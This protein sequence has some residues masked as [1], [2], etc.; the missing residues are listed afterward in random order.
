MGRAAQQV[1]AQIR[2]DNVFGRDETVQ[3]RITEVYNA[4]VAQGLASVTISNDDSLVSM[5]TEAQAITEGNPSGEIDASVPFILSFTRVGDLSRSASV[6]YRVSEWGD[7]S[8]SSADFF[9]GSFPS[10]QVQFAAGSATASVV[11]NL[12][13]EALFES[14]E[15]FVVRLLTSTSVPAGSRPASVNPDAA[16]TV[17]TIKN[18]DAA[19]LSLSAVTS[20][21]LE[22][23]NAANPSALS[24]EAV[25]TGD[26][27]QAVTVTYT[28]SRVDTSSLTASAWNATF[29]QSLTGSFVISAGE[30]K[31][32]FA[33]PLVANTLAEPDRNLRVTLS[34][35]G[36]Q[37]AMATATVLDDDTGISIARSGD[38]SVT[39]GSDAAQPRLTAFVVTRAG[40]L[41]AARVSWAVSPL[42]LN[43]IDAADFV[44]GQDALGN[45]GGL[46]S[47]ELAFAEGEVSKTINVRVVADAVI[48]GTEA[49]SVRLLGVALPSLTASAQ[50]ILNAVAEARITDDDTPSDA[51][52]DTVQ[53]GAGVDLLSG[54]GGND[55]IQ[56]G[57]GADRVFG[58]DG[59]D[60][61]IGGGGGDAIFSGAGDD[62]I[63]LNGDNIDSF[64]EGMLARVDGGLGIDT[65]RL[66]GAG[67]TI[68]LA[69]ILD[70][71]DTDP[72]GCGRIAGIEKIDLTGQGDN[73]LVV[74]AEDVV[75]ISCNN[76]FEPTGRYQLV[77]TGN[78]GDRVDLADGTGTTG[79]VQ[80]TAV[81]LDQL[82]F[83][84]WNSTSVDATI[85]VH[86]GVLVV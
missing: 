79:W 38:L 66:A 55:L 39:E 19:P 20:A 81:T 77:V 28:V 30:A 18:D 36:Y 56:A 60:T 9:S 34:A 7:G 57:A 47:G 86:T 3:L 61:I 85:Y 6:D 29:G 27:S 62:L 33:V 52:A 45:Q 41:G 17:V 78:S 67:K 72:G 32:V 15:T 59:A 11:L 48:E 21:A 53:G 26:V 37:N 68:D 69:S 1:A 74:G 5:Q 43:G 50:K 63:V 22:G 51:T 35:A 23:N 46:P 71:G 49:F 4:S 24:F 16:V 65:L 76:V 54:G 82:Q 14:D 25:R 10:G 40:S 80:G 64:L 13:G 83:I 12:R 73:A 8:A 31:S 2:G 70:T 44:A 75:A 58:G 42:G 84:A